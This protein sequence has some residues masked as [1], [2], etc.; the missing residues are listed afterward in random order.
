MKQTCRGD[1]L[2]GALLLAVTLPTAALLAALRGPLLGARTVL[3]FLIVL[4]KA[5]LFGNV[6]LP[7]AALPALLHV[8]LLG[9]QTTPQPDRS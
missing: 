7:T 9:S 8:P 3:R 4:P 6:A 5:V 2:G 1:L